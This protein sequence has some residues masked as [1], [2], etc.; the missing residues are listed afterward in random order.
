MKDRQLKFFR[1]P[2]ATQQSKWL[3]F[4]YEGGTNLVITK[5]GILLH[6]FANVKKNILCLI[7]HA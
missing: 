4:F 3:A 7:L 1:L 2:Q 6:R 5:V